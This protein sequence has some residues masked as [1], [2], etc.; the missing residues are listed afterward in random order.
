MSIL[1]YYLRIFCFFY[2]LSELS[3]FCISKIIPNSSSRQM[4]LTTVI[5]NDFNHS[6]VQTSLLHSFLCMICLF[7]LSSFQIKKISRKNI[8]FH[9]D[10]SESRLFALFQWRYLYSLNELSH[11]PS[12]I[13]PDHPHQEI[14]RAPFQHFPHRSIIC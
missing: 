1:C 12:H 6:F 11:I 10:L 4:F 3:I 2:K 14:L 13:K 5:Y 9:P 7:H 8:R